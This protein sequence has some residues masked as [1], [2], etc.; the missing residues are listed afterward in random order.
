MSEERIKSPTFSC[1]AGLVG[2]LGLIG[3]HYHGH[4]NTIHPNSGPISSAKGFFTNNIGLN[5]IESNGID[6]KI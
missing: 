1:T 5:Y 3:N 2:Q 4:T 6:L